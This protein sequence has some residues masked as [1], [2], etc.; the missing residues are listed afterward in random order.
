MAASAMS[1]LRSIA[2]KAVWVASLLYHV[3]AQGTDSSWTMWGGNLNNTRS[4]DASTLISQ[5]TVSNLAVAWNA[6]VTGA[7]SASPLVHSGVTVFPTWAG[8]V[9]SLNS[10]TGNVVWQTTVDDYISSP[11]CEAPMEYNVSA[12]GVLSRTTPAL[13]GA[14]LIVIGTQFSMPAV[15]LAGLPYVMGELLAASYPLV[16]ALATS[17]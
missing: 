10:S 13:A 6:S 8:Q 9:Y 3:T 14:D 2:L 16:T 7:V 1:Y 15:P 5:T 11:L 12:S 17:Y 4:A